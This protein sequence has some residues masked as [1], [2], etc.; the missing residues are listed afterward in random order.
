MQS[1]DWLSH[2][3]AGGRVALEAVPG[4]GKTFHLLTACRGRKCILLAY[5]TQ[6]AT[7]TQRHLTR[8]GLD[9]T[10][11]ITFH[12]LCGR[13][14]K[15]ARDDAQLLEAVEMAEHG[16]LSPKEVPDVDC[17]LIDEAQDV[18]HLYVRLL[19]VLGLTR[20]G[21][22]MLVAGDRRQL[23]YDFDPEFPAT[24]TTLLEPETTF[25]GGAAAWSHVTLTHTR[26]LTSPMAQFVNAMFG[27]SIES[28]RED[29]Q[30]ALPVEVRVP[31]RSMFHLTELLKDIVEE[32]TTQGN[33]L[34]I[35]ADRK[36]N[37]RPLT[38]LLNS[39]SRQGK[40]VFVHGI[41]AE[42]SETVHGQMRC[43][44]YWSSKGL[45]CDTCV[46][47]LPKASASNPT[48]VALT[49]ARR[50]LIVI[51]DP[52]EPHAAAS[53]AAT[54]GHEKGWVHIRGIE[55]V[56]AIENGM[57]LD[58]SASLTTREEEDETTEA[59]ADAAAPL[60]RDVDRWTPSRTLLASTTSFED[61]EQGGSNDA[62]LL[63][64]MDSGQ[65]CDM[66]MVVV[67]MALLMAEHRATGQIRAMEDILHPLRFEK[68]ADKTHE[69]A[70]ALA[71]RPIPMFIEEDALLAPDLRKTAEA[72]YRKFRTLEDIAEVALATLAWDGYDH[73]MRQCLP[74]CAWVHNESVRTAIEWTLQ[75]IPVNAEDG[76][77]YDHRIC[78]G[79]QHCRVQ[80]SHPTRG[81]FYVTWGR[82]SDDDGLAAVRAALHHSRHLTLLDVSER[83]VICVQAK[84][85]KALLE[86]AT[87][88]L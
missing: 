79:V 82:S 21:K 18:R 75:N 71:S 43:G 77:M 14:L 6:L 45:E 54:E 63:L 46:V 66:G 31:K 28:I 35:L 48:Y 67:R 7:E 76:A 16:E 64:T 12:A 9:D 88:L 8:L 4:A 53:R 81:V 57:K 59:E 42:D 22:S 2:L 84:D 5:N 60:R 30:E 87:F 13:C 56:R 25:G 32:T 55:A 78:H 68:G 61:T 83:R 50:R 70:H 20:S 44:S 58:A 10:L 24:L 11:C 37:N 47:I 19:K 1:H 36:R 40:N 49:R 26:R 74:V 34:L 86:S 62:G 3:D 73:T 65:S 72:A 33:T 80:V 15:V 23:V 17:V 27:S 38:T 51:L 41:D 39:Y 52:K 85:S 69:M 29:P